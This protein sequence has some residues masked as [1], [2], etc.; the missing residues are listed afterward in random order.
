MKKLI[1]T[2]SII[3]VIAMLSGTLGAISINAED[4][5]YTPADVTAYLYSA[6]SEK[7]ITCLFREDLPDAPYIDPI[8]YLNVIY[9]DLFTEQL[10]DDGTYTITNAYEE[11]MVIDPA[12]DTIYF[13]NYDAFTD[14]YTNSEG[15]SVSIDYISFKEG[16]YSVEPSAVTLDLSAYNIDI[17]EAD[18]KVYLPLVVLGAMFSLTYNNAFYYNGNIL[19]VHTMDPEGYQYMIDE[20]YRYEELTRSEAM[21]QFNYD[22]LCFF[23]DKFYGQPS[24]ALLGPGIA[25]VG[26]DKALDELDEY[27]PFVKELLLSTDMIEYFHGLMI[28]GYYLHD[29]GHTVTYYPPLLG[30]NYYGDTPLADAWLGSFLSEEDEIG[31][32]SYYYYSLQMD[33]YDIDFTLPEVRA[34][35]Y[36]KYE[37]EIVAEWE[38][39]A[40]LIIHGD[41]AVFVFDSFEADTPYEFKEA[42]DIAK[43][44]GVVNFLIDDSCNSGGYVAAFQYICTLITNAKYRS[45]KFSV[46]NLNPL[47]GS[48][49]ESVCYLDLNLDGEFNEADCDVYYDF[50]FAILTS[51]CAFSCGNELPCNARQRGILI[52]GEHSGGGSCYVTE[53]YL[54][55]GFY[56][57]ISDIAKSVLPDGS[58]VDLGAPVDYDLTAINEEDGSVDYTGLYDLDHLSELMS[59]FYKTVT[60][61]D[62]DG[63]IITTAKYREGDEIIVPAAP[64]REKDEKFEYIFSDWDSE[65]APTCTGDA[66]YTAVYDAEQWFFPG[67]VN[68][69]SF[70]TAL[71]RLI[72]TRYLAGWAGYPDMVNEK[73]A[74]INK[75]G[76][77]S[78]MD[79]LLL[80]R[81]LAGWDGYEKWFE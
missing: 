43:E 54:A 26:M 25:E 78:A 77:V 49:A 73:A 38:S 28:L 50:N 56:V 5:V 61:V 65:I 11:T 16:F 14:C 59:G 45:N 57:P 21:A 62:Y 70:V 40:Y 12:A 42:L 55:D 80:S 68:N 24:N 79:R 37:E 47:T 27:T 4:A 9:T 20:S 30:A 15:S 76:R 8:D 64:T 81:Y 1:K 29:G 35:E 13:A 75:D 53:R 48:V 44:S 74:D 31:L 67:D 63:T 33:M 34:N 2:I 58:D 51:P 6:E 41:L 22:S 52:L 39:G 71:D 23:M 18:G 7:T 60:F 69:D 10:N 66:V 3:V 19:F 46:A 72:L 36:E 32:M 17:A